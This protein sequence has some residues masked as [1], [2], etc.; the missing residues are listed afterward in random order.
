ML[1]LIVS[2]VETKDDLELVHVSFRTETGYG[3][4]AVLPLGPAAAGRLEP[5]KEYVLLD[6]SAT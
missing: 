2:K 6:S 1:R 4:A 3:G 5:G